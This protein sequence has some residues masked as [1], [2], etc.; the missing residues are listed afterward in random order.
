MKPPAK[1]KPWMRLEEMGVWVREAPTRETYQKRV[2]IWLASLYSFPAHQIA[3][4][5]QVSKQAVWLWIGQYNKNGPEGLERKGRG[6][7]RWA[8]LTIDD[9]VSLLR[10]FERSAAQGE[11]LTAKQMKPKI[12]QAVGKKVSLGY[13]YNL[14]HRHSWR[15]IGPRPKHVKADREAQAA[16][17]KTSRKSSGR[18]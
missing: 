6:G 12:E 11:I 4:M 17:K 14:L 9:E 7:R 13:V 18:R 8:F 5:L 10:S 2:V 3:D 1:I 16:F 15:K